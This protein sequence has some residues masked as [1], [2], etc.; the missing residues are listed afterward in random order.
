MSVENNKS[1]GP[2]GV[3]IGVVA[4]ISGLLWLHGESP[5]P[6]PVANHPISASVIKHSEPA[7]Q[8]PLPVP[9]TR[10]K[11]ED[12]IK[13]PNSAIACVDRDSLTIILEHGAKGEAT[14][15]QA[16]MMNPKKKTGSCIMLSPDKRYKV[17][18]AEYNDPNIEIGLL[19]IVGNGI[20]S[21]SGAWTLSVGSVLTSKL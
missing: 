2:V 15:M 18:S 6:D 13:F 5:S 9:S 4:L 3:A 12:I 17:I 14:K 10:I 21:D 1:V 7:A 19:E 11:P 20:V 16:M 8:P